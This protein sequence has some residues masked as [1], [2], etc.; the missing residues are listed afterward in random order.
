MSRKYLKKKSFN[1]LDYNHA[2]HSDADK[3]NIAYGIDKKLLLAVVSLLHRFL[4]T[5]RRR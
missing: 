5:Q 3:F 4:T 2:Q 1:I